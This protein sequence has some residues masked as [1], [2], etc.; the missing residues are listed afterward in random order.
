MSAT[1]LWDDY[2][3]GKRNIGE[4]E[5]I[6]R[7][8]SGFTNGALTIVVLLLTLIL[9]FGRIIRLV[10]AI[11]MF[12]SILGFLQYQKHFCVSFGIT[13]KCNFD[14]NSSY[15][16]RRVSPSDLRLDRINALLVCIQALIPTLLLTA[17]FFII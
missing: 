3:P 13:G 11:P 15:V 16:Y 17:L 6:V 10:I 7:L 4:K 2:R 8:S 1:K 9:P 5:R 14:N 12:F